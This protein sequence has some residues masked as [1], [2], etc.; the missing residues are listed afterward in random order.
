MTTVAVV[1]TMIVDGMAIATGATTAAGMAIAVG[2]AIAAGT[3]H[4]GAAPIMAGATRAAGPSGAGITACA[5]AV[6]LSGTFRAVA[7]AAARLPL[8]CN[9]VGSV[10]S[11]ELAQPGLSV[12]VQIGNVSDPS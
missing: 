1:G 2:T 10:N 6:E 12:S 11:P 7:A 8:E 3:G 9:F 5:S 4:I